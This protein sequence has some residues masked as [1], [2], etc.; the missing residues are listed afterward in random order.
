[1]CMILHQ[2]LNYIQITR[3]RNDYHNCFPCGVAFWNWIREPFGNRFNFSRW[4]WE[5]SDIFLSGGTRIHLFVQDVTFI[6]FD[7]HVCYMV[8]LSF[9]MWSYWLFFTFRVELLFVLYFQCAVFDSSPLSSLLNEQ[10]ESP[11]CCASISSTIPSG[12]PCISSRWWNEILWLC[13]LCP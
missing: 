2:I 4:R 1:M 12:K 3:R 11:R 7:V 8:K 13:V 10:E 9:W 5:S 6:Y